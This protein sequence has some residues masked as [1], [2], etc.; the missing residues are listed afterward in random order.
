M[1]RAHDG[2]K[3]K[4]PALKITSFVMM[5]FMNGKAVCLDDNMFTIGAFFFFRII[6]QTQMPDS[7]CAFLTQTVPSTCSNP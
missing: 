6:V 5:K 1:R 3:K 4:Q 2:K 7:Y